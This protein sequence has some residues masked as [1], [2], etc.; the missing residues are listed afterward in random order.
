MKHK[1]IIVISIASVIIGI[2]ITF[3]IE[4]YFGFGILILPVIVAVGVFPK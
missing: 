3:L 1:F 4:Y 2:I